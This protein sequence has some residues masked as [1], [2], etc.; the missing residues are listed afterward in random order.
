[1]QKKLIITT[2]LT[3]VLMCA[4]SH[5]VKADGLTKVNM[6][7]YTHTGHCT[8]SGVM[9]Y[10][11]GC[12]FQSKHIGSKVAVYQ[13]MNGVPGPLIGVFDINDTGYG[14]PTKN[15]NPKTNKPYGTIQMGWSIDI[16]QD[17]LEDCRTFIKTYGDKCFIK[18][19]PPKEVQDG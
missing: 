9:P 16:F 12:A 14:A 13:N 6:T 17:S 1:M 4:M 3:V 10:V 18:I 11:G 5:L 15:I 19:I 8:A 2:L 7:C